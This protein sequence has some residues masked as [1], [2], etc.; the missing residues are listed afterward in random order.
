MFVPGKPSVMQHSSKM[1]LIVSNEE[2]EVL[3]IQ[4]LYLSTLNI[5]VA[6]EHKAI[7]RWYYKNI[8]FSDKKHS[9]F[10]FFYKF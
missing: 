9:D 2:N 1:G 4:P 5:G 6:V 8:I 7:F 10:V 3:W